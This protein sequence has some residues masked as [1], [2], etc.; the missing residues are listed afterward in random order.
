[1]P[2]IEFKTYHTIRFGKVPDLS[3]IESNLE[4]VIN[5]ANSSRACNTLAEFAHAQNKVDGYKEKAAKYYMQSAD[6]GCLI[7]THWIGVFYQEGFGVTKNL[8]KSIELLNKAA[9][10]GNAQS[11]FQLFLLYSREEE[12]KDVKLAYKNLSKAVQLGVTYFDQLNE[13]FKDNYDV[14]AP[15]FLE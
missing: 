4:K 8:D 11:N 10:M 7:G 9:K 2:A 13:F 5:E 3:K 15:I 12:K 1:L 6:L 14:L